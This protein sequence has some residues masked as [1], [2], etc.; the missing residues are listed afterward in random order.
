MD[1]TNLL[2]YRTNQ[3]LHDLS[4]RLIGHRLEPTR[5]LVVVTG[6]CSGL[7]KELVARLRHQGVRV[8]VLDVQ[9]IPVFER[10]DGA[11]YFKCDVSKVDDLKRCRKLIKSDLGPP[12]VLINNAAIMLGKNILDSTFDE[13]D[14]I[15]RVNLMSHFYTT[16]VFLP[17]MMTHHRGYI[18]TVASVLGLI[19]PAQFAAYGASKAGLFAFHESLT[20]ELGPPSRSLYGVKTLLLCPGQLRTNMFSGLRTPSAYLA[21][22]LDPAMVASFLI[23]AL[24]LGRRGEIKIPV[25][26]R[27]LPVLRAFPWPISE[28]ARNTFHLDRQARSAKGKLFLLSSDAETTPAQTKPSTSK[29]KENLAVTKLASD[30]VY[31]TNSLLNT[32]MRDTSFK[33]HMT[34]RPA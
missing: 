5:D 3:L 2:I 24:R 12:S 11:H 8:A 20:Y 23:E 32:L 13:V 31:H 17:D 1:L 27:F 29:E 7:G 19:S 34:G 6:G 22:E 33:T 21:P 26:A 10:V 18:V 28:A 25:Y 14:K 30:K 9:E 16:K 4:K 15:I